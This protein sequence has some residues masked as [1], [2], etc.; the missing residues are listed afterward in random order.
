MGIQT[1]TFGYI[2]DWRIAAIVV[3][4]VGIVVGIIGLSMSADTDDQKE[5]RSAMLIAGIIL[6][7]I[8]FIWN[9]VK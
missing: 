2:D 6:F 1:D 7:A 9:L 5:K 3:L 4:V 8:G